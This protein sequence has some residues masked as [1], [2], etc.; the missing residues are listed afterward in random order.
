M[1][2]KEL[3]K[4]IPIFPL[5]GALLLPMG[6]LPLNIF[7]PRYLSMIDYAMKNDKIIGMIQENPKSITSNNLYTTGCIGKI[8]QY[9]ETS[10]GRYLINLHGQIRFNFIEEIKT[11]EKFRKLKVDY[12]K[13]ENDTV[14]NFEKNFKKDA[15]LEEVKNYL[16]RNNIE[17]DWQQ[18][19]KVDL[20]ILITTL[21]S[22][23]PFSVA[24]KQMILECPNTDEIPTTMLNL[25]RMGDNNL[26]PKIIN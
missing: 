7:E 3:P 15:F 17:F 13:F 26:G 11:D 21:A 24:E 25:F 8:N 10:D 4:I 14:N 22:I 12:S 5:S 9:N 6:N 19:K 2:I 18:I 20:T 23:C 16:S 1:N